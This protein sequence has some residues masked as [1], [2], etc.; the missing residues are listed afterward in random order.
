MKLRSLL[1]RRRLHN[2][3]LVWRWQAWLNLRFTRSG[4][5]MLAL[6]L[7]SGIL[8]LN[9]RQALGY[10]IFGFVSAALLLAMLVTLRWLQRMPHNFKISRNLPPHA[11]VGARA[12]YYFQLC[13]EGKQV[14]HGYS[15]L[16]CPHDPR[17]SR[18]QFE[19][20]VEPGAEQRN[21]FD[22]SVGYYRWA[23][24]LHMNRITHIAELPLPAL[25]PGQVLQISHGFTP[26]ARGNLVLSGVW[27]ARTDPFGFCR[28]LQFIELPATM[29]VLPC[30]W[31][32]PPAP[33]PVARHAQHQFAASVSGDGE[34]FVGLRAY[35]P[36]DSLRIVHWKSFA[37]LGS[38]VV[39]EYQTE[40]FTR[41]AILLD[42]VQAP[43][44]QAFEDAIALAASLVANLHRP[45]YLLDLLYIDSDCQS[46]TCGHG[47]LQVE[48]LLHIL[49]GLQASRHALLRQLQSLLLARY[50]ELSACVCVMLQWDE[51]RAQFVRQVQELGLPLQV[52]LVCAKPHSDLPH[53]LP[54]WLRLFQPGQ[55]AEQLL[56]MQDAPPA[57]TSSL[58]S[59]PQTTSQT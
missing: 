15:L 17:P 9:T 41:Y 38:P 8:G 24:L 47:Q 10:Q 52:W 4:Q 36:G 35:R 32:T 58:S 44:G 42:T 43:A 16:E 3:G 20:A 22:R 39:K 13:H 46:A 11:S 5:F 2:F 37:R 53:P 51:A 57:S 33:L 55:C 40:Y 29:L 7:A 45:D 30:T 59:Q 14:L 1:R 50:D 54:N 31:P 6:L 28:A 23:W 34:E 21:W 49:A 25:V 56:A 12:Q 26:F 19:H 48:A 27:L 18:A